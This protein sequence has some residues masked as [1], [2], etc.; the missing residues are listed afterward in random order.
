MQIPQHT[1]WELLLLSE[2]FGVQK[3][4]AQCRVKLLHL[5]TPPGQGTVAKHLP[6]GVMVGIDAKYIESIEERLL[7]HLLQFGQAVPAPATNKASSS[8]A[9]TNTRGNSSDTS[10]NNTDVSSPSSVMTSPASEQSMLNHQHQAKRSRSTADSDDEDAH[11]VDTWADP[12]DHD[13]FLPKHAAV[14]AVSVGVQADDA[15]GPMLPA[16]PASAYAPSPQPL[17]QV[18]SILKQQVDATAHPSTPISPM[19]PMTPSSQPFTP[20]QAH[21]DP[22][23][24]R[25]RSPSPSAVRWMSSTRSNPD[26][27]PVSYLY[28]RDRDRDRDRDARED[29]GEGARRPLTGD[30]LRLSREVAQLRVKEARIEQDLLATRTRAAVAMKENQLASLRLKTEIMRLGSMQSSSSSSSQRSASAGR[31]NTPRRRNEAVAMRSIE[32]EAE[33]IANAQY[34]AMRRIQEQR[35]REKEKERK[36]A[37]EKDLETM[38]RFQKRD[39][40]IAQFIQKQHSTRSPSPPPPPPAPIPIAQPQRPRQSPSAVGSSRPAARSTAPSSSSRAPAEQDEHMLVYSQEALAAVGLGKSPS[41]SQRSVTK[42]VSRSHDS[43]EQVKAIKS[44]RPFN[45]GSKVV[46][47]VSV[48]RAYDLQE[49]LPATNA[50]VTVAWAGASRSAAPVQTQAVPD[51]IA[52]YFG[53]TLPLEEA[54]YRDYDDSDKTIVFKV[55]NRNVSLSDNLL[56]WAELPLRDL[57]PPHIVDYSPRTTGGVLVVHL[58]DSTRRPAGSLEVS[59]SRYMPG[60]G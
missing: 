7:A 20:R 21:S 38:K 28:S 2:L 11:S 34:M 58:M 1:I 19:T 4:F 33:V 10:S 13:V 12:N 51:T 17:A 56:G 57:L 18:R 26:S 24:A 35:R 37:K 5:F 45:A 27:T 47:Q 22:P 59:V 41:H 16:T 15:A 55:C 49:V 23:P 31:S 14:R 39:E 40:R 52:P 9:V 44:H 3:V 53:S 46:Y 36:Q 6:P 30:D 60:A 54:Y 50:Y 43:A 32:Q 8:P 25:R 42:E 48:I 29:S